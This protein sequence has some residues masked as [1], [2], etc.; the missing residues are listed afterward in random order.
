MVKKI[1]DLSF[2]EAKAKG[3]LKNWKRARKIK[4]S[5]L[6]YHRRQRILKEQFKIDIKPKVKIKKIIGNRRQ[7]TLNFVNREIADTGLIY[8]SIRA[9]T[10]NNEITKT[11]LTIA[12]YSVFKKYKNTLGLESYYK[13]EPK[14]YI[15]YENK[16]VSNLEDKKLNDGSVWIEIF[17]NG[18]AQKT[19]N[20]HNFNETQSQLK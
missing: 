10:K 3:I 6:E 15:G 11:G 5:M 19:F 17:Y 9:I 2:Q 14:F 8:V 18:K 4:K 12:V 1:S 7:I 16:E 20:Y 13:Y